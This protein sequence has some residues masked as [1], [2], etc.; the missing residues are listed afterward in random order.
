MMHGGRNCEENQR[1][2]E[3]EET[4]PAVVACVAND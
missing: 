2:R 1:A 4:N 3:V